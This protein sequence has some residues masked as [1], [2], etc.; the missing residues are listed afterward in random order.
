MTTMTTSADTSRFDRLLLR[1][2]PIYSSLDNQNNVD[3]NIDDNNVN[4]NNDTINATTNTATIILP[5]HGLHH[6]CDEFPLPVTLGRT[7]FAAPWWGV[8]RLR[9]LALNLRTRKTIVSNHSPSNHHTCNKTIT[10]KTTATNKTHRQ[11]QGRRRRH[12]RC[13]RVSNFAW[14]ELFRKRHLPETLTT[15]GRLTSDLLK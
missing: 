1:L 4:N 11:Q 2:T 9:A 6:H 15:S 14:F 13:R 8:D 12:E 5:T 3:N 7:A 10:I